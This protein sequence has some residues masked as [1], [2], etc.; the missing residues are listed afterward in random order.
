MACTATATR[1]IHEDVV[2]ILE[3]SDY[4][5]VSLPPDRPNI[6]YEVKK[7]TDPA[8]DLHELL[9]SLRVHLISAPRVVVYCKTLM[10]CAELFSHF[11][12]EMG[13]RQYYPPGALHLSDNRLFGMFH[14][15]TP[16]HS[17][18]V[19]TQSLLDPCGVV[20]I[21]FASVAMGMGVDLQGVNTIIHYG[22][23]SSIEDYF[24]ASG[25]GGRKGE[26]ACS[27][28]YWTRTD[29]PMWKNPTTTHQREV[30]CVRKYLDNSSICRRKWLLEYFDP[31]NAKPGEDPI[32]CC[33]VCEAMALSECTLTF[34]A[35]E[36]E[37]CDI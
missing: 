15:S 16:Q 12:Y 28:I 31:K 33:D 5:S 13:D 35:L 10:M 26:S 27:R 29:C 21:V 24:Q 4:V 9:K 37:I 32:T 34:P 22:A 18:E 25:R 19:I 8:I 3:M 7:R 36:A 23:P 14:A 6:K 17:K 20:R 11:S 2:K 30:N 1:S